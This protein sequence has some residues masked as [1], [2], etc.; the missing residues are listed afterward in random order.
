MTATLTHE[1]NKEEFLKL[2]TRNLALGKIAYETRFGEVDG[3][4]FD[5]R[6]SGVDPDEWVMDHLGGYDDLH[7]P[8][9]METLPFLWFPWYGTFDLNK[10]KAEVLAEFREAKEYARNGPPMP[11]EAY[12]DITDAEYED[13]V[14][15]EKKQRVIP[16]TWVK[17]ELKFR[18]PDA[19]VNQGDC[20]KVH[21][22]VKYISQ[23]QF[24]HAHDSA[25]IHL[26]VKIISNNGL[27]K[28]IDAP[29]VMFGSTKLTYRFN[30]QKIYSI[31][32]RVKKY[33]GLSK[34]N[35]SSVKSV[36]E[37]YTKGG[38]AHSALYRAV[39]INEYFLPR[40][41][42]WL[43]ADN[44]RRAKIGREFL[45]ALDDACML[46]YAWAYAETEQHMR[47][48][49]VAGAAARA[50][51]AR[52]GQASGA[53]RRAKA[54]DTWQALIKKEAA[55]IRGQ[56]PAV[57]QANLADEL[58]FKFDDEVPSHPIIVRHIARLERE[59]ELPRRRIMNANA[60]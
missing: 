56:N 50:G 53:R 18:I 17:D 46:G 31:I 7:T 2:R 28:V 4:S 37:N 52:A 11:R 24:I 29:I 40:V 38:S 22:V 19:I 13:S 9:R 25:E 47:P 39:E 49:A 3:I 6:H 21:R 43:H 42:K 20:V 14:R 41:W 32:D 54:A 5:L 35:R 30:H 23:D 55:I 1:F 33:H 10:V 60:L 58:K 51:A 12:G 44:N 34:L 8:R 57:S 26:Q 27:F 59:G 36:S 15:E 16:K 48:L 45:R